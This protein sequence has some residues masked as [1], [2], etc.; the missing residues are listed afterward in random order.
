MPPN[1]ENLRVKKKKSSEVS[2]Q[3]QAV[4]K[5]NPHKTSNIITLA[6][7]KLTEPSTWQQGHAA[8]KR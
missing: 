4:D 8:M 3:I 7:Q 2:G 5:K 1:I 6:W